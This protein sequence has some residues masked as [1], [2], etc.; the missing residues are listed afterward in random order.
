MQNFEL[1]TNLIDSEGLLEC[2]VE[3]YRPLERILNCDFMGVSNQQVCP[4]EYN[5]H[6]AVLYWTVVL[7]TSMWLNQPKLEPHLAIEEF[8][9]AAILT[10]VATIL[11][12]VAV[13]LAFD[14]L[15]F[16]KML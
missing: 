6:P 14:L 2:D 5:L 15:Y 12:I 3:R 13:V 1:M 4:R 8:A 9:V 11:G 16:L 10:I 7:L